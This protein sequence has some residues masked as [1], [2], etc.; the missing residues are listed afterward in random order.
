MLSCNE[1][2]DKPSQNNVNVSGDNFNEKVGNDSRIKRLQMTAIRMRPT[3]GGRT[4]IVDSRKVHAGANK[5]PPATSRVQQVGR[6]YS[7]VANASQRNSSVTF[8]FSNLDTE[9]K[10]QLLPGDSL[11]PNHRRMSIPELPPIPSQ[12]RN[13]PNQQPVPTSRVRAQRLS[14]H[15]DS[16]LSGYPSKS[17]H[18][19]GSSTSSHSRHLSPVPAD[20]QS[21]QMI[22]MKTWSADQTIK[23]AS[24][25][26]ETI[27]ATKNGMNFLSTKETLNSRYSSQEKSSSSGSGVKKRLGHSHSE[28]QLVKIEPRG[29][30]RSRTTMKRNGSDNKLTEARK[31]TKSSAVNGKISVDKNGALICSKFNSGNV[32]GMRRYSSTVAI[33]QIGCNSAYPDAESK[34]ND[35]ED[36]MENDEVK[37]RRIIDWIVGVDRAEPPPDPTI[38]YADE[39][40][41]TDTAVHIVYNGD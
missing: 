16:S 32:N 8:D 24:E 17:P 33:D 36:D 41:Q 6:T 40:P 14:R 12:K 20:L 13:S 11:L 9:K 7:I 34:K 5:L 37:N 1:T 23:E 2:T 39:P 21:R 27:A 30:S 31:Y 15:S 25:K 10:W 18:S 26:L 3:R 35:T 19:Q 22:R 28:S 38:Y 29:I 4:R